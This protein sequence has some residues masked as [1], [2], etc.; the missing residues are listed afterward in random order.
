MRPCNPLA[1]CFV[2][3]A[4]LAGT[5]TTHTFLYTGD[6]WRTISSQ[7]QIKNKLDGPFRLHLAQI[8]N[9]LAR[10]STIIPTFFQAAIICLHSATSHQ[11]FC[12]S[13]AAQAASMAHL[14]STTCSFSTHATCCT[15]TRSC[16]SSHS[17]SFSS[18]SSGS[19]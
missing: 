19:G 6:P 3:M 5:L 1:L 14:A 11:S 12:F 10:T 17:F 16:F 15:S 9:L 13:T 2:D 18:H 4:S 8:N 7:L